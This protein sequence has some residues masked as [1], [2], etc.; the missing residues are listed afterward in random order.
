MKKT[1]LS[2]MFLVCAFSVDAQT[3][4]SLCP[5]TGPSNYCVGVGGSFT[6]S[7]QPV[8]G[9]TSYQWILWAGSS[10]ATLSSYTTSGPSTTLFITGQATADIPIDIRAFN[11]S[12]VQI[13]DCS[14][15]VQAIGQLSTITNISVLDDCSNEYICTS[16]SG[17]NLYLWEA[18]GSS[19][20]STTTVFNQVTL[21]SSFPSGSYTLRV[22]AQNSCGGQ[23]NWQERQITVQSQSGP[24]N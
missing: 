15:L 1:I 11:N 19:T 2:F 20:W 12:S 3:Y 10:S 9:A 17:A 14:G 16:I 18:V 5:F 21:G 13:G 23:T 7:V 22:K 24:C 6:I 8:P 4:Y